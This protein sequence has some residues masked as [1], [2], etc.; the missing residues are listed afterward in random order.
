MVGTIGYLGKVRFA[1]G[2]KCALLY[3]LAAAASGILLGTVL[4]STGFLLSSML[5]FLHVVPSY[6]LT[7]LAVLIL[8]LCVV[9][10]SFAPKL[11]FPQRRQQVPRGYWYYH[12]PRM[13]SL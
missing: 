5:V 2:L 6:V 10:E 7:G 9:L 12:G 11:W 1:L 13:A 3:T 4:G 8:F